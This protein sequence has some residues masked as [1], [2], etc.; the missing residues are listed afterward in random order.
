MWAGSLSHNSLTGCGRGGRGRIGDWASHQLEQRAERHVRRH[1]RGRSGRRLGG[2]VPVCH[3]RGPGAVR[4]LRPGGDGGGYSRLRRGD[5]AGRI[6]AFEHFLRSIGMPT[7]VGQLGITLDEQ[8][9]ESWPGCVPLRAGAPLAPLRCWAWRRSRIS[10]GRPDKLFMK[11]AVAYRF[12]YATAFFI[13]WMKSDSPGGFQRSAGHVS[14]LS[15]VL[16]LPLL[17]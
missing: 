7:T 2:L 5:R 11:N 10:T 16:V 3:G 8:A 4:P 15:A 13:E 17:L 6:R 9:I 1:P 14:G 12:R